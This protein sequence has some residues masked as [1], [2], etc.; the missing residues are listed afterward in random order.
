MIELEKRL[1]NTRVGDVQKTNEDEFL[2]RLETRLQNS[3]EDRRTMMT[4]FTMLIVICMLT[5][6]QYGV[7]DR[8]DSVYYVDEMENLLETD[9]W[10]IS[11]DSLAYDESYLNDMAYFLLE[12]G[13]LW[14]TYELINELEQEE[15]I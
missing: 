14:E 3:R 9:L 13:Y 12:E 8:L 1:N 15:E 5:I 4:S 7:P 10:N 2:S 6:T 11:G